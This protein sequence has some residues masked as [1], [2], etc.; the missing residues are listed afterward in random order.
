MAAGVTG[1]GDAKRA[2]RLMQ[3]LE[4][5]MQQAREGIVSLEQLETRIEAGT[6]GNL[7][8]PFLDAA[9]AIQRTL[10]IEEVCFFLLACLTCCIMTCKNR[11]LFSAT[12]HIQLEAATVIPECALACQTRLRAC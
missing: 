9:R 10:T 12:G 3:A 11:G 1:V 8:A 5:A 4:T 7:A 2:L 6:Q